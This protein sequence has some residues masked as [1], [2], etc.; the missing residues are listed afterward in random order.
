M[1]DLTPPME[2]LGLMGYRIQPSDVG[3]TLS[4]IIQT[5]ADE[6]VAEIERERDDKEGPRN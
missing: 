4:D 1:M 3:R 2:W 5:R 6:R